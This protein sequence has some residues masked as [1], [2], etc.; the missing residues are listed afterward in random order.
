M[1]NPA[2]VPTPPAD[3]PDDLAA[4]LQ[5]LSEHDLRETI[6][7]AQELL[8]ANNV[9]TEQIEPA[10]G[11]E[12]VEMTE[13]PGYTEVVK[14]QPCGQDCPDCPHGPYVYHVT[15]ERHPD[16]TERFHWVFIGQQVSE[17]P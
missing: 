17:T 5:Q 13:H 9:P 2:D 16:G 3:F 4:L 12:I 15:R 10:P 6:I 14:R 8:Q 1:T 7:Y 11:E